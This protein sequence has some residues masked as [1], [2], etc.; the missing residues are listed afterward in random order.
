MERR[1]V[2]GGTAA[3]GGVGDYCSSFLTLAYYPASNEGR[4]TYLGFP[5]LPEVKIT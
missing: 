4:T 1:A 3:E 2:G 5:V